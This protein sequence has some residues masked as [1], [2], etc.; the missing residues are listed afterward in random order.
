M[1]D[2][3]VYRNFLMNESSLP[4]GY[5]YAKN[6]YEILD[7]V[8]CRVFEID[9]TVSICVINE[10][11]LK[12]IPNSDIYTDP[13]KP[14]LGYGN[15]CYFNC[16]VK[17]MHLINCCDKPNDVKYKAVILDCLRNFKYAV[18]TTIVV[19]RHIEQKYLDRIFHDN[20]DTI[21]EL[22][23]KIPD[24]KLRLLRRILSDFDDKYGINLS[25]VMDKLDIDIIID[26]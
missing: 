9:L 19:M 2:S 8:K 1:T 4:Y 16:I 12:K 11:E 13:D 24:D 25:H 3:Q 18:T 15:S 23:K 20:S 5:L 6:Y 22:I 14:S 10:D 7:A 21:I 17:A 26:I